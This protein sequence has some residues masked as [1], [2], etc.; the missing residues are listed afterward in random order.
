MNWN[1]SDE[2]TTDPFLFWRLKNLLAIWGRNGRNF[3]KDFRGFYWILSKYDFNQFLMTDHS[4]GGFAVGQGQSRINTLSEF[5]RFL[6][7]NWQREVILIETLRIFKEV[8][9]CPGTSGYLMENG[10]FE[11]K[12]KIGAPIVLHTPE[13]FKIREQYLPV[14]QSRESYCKAVTLNDKGLTLMP[15]VSGKDL[16]GFILYETG[17]LASNQIELAAIVATV[18]SMALKNARQVEEKANI[19]DI[20][21]TFASGLDL[22]VSYELFTEKLK[23]IVPV[24]LI[25]I[26]LPDPFQSNQLMVYGGGKGKFQKNCIPYLGSGSALVINTG[27]TIVEDDL[28]ENRSFI[29]D[30]MLL[31]QGLRCVLRAPLTSKGKTFGTLNVGSRLPGVFSRREVDLVTE[32]AGK[33]GPAVENALVYDA[34][35][36]KLSQALIRIENNYS[37]TL[38]AM[39]MML[40]KRDAGTKGH[41]FRVIR[42]A[43]KIAE[44]MG[45]SGKELENIRLGSLLHDIGKIAI[46]DAILFKPGRLNVQEMLV[47]KNHPRI[48]A[49]MV[50]KIDFLSP[51]A[52]IVLHHHEW[53]NGHGYPAGLKKEEI[54]FGAR[55]FAIADAF[56]AMTSDRPYRAGLPMEQAIE[57]L[58]KYKASQFCPECID[59]F[60][61]ISKADLI[62]MF[63]DCQTEVTFRSPELAGKVLNWEVAKSLA[64]GN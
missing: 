36:K 17:D 41:S 30:E 49:D 47:M 21:S 33:I 55:V 62:T 38:N 18:A 11:L 13:T 3:R 39:A 7:G 35:N 8:V 2:L 61:K 6:N 34:I 42:Y 64:Q 60:N 45:V 31:G 48:G 26:I 20:V 53:F 46:P 29:E 25:T 40:D 9:G 19:D 43:S 16:F 51:A 32:I 27:D 1:G 14:F 58:A 57:E 56:D 5:A 23:H 59:A 50:S 37:A 12:A 4:D 54:P 28:A 10:N 24:Y 15:L 52:P 44:K 22:E 63:N